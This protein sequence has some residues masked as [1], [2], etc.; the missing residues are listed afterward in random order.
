MFRVGLN[1]VT[2]TPTF[3]EQ[4]RMSL[5][6]VQS[7]FATIFDSLPDR[8]K[9]ALLEE[10]LFPL[11]D[12]LSST[13]KLKLM[14]AAE[15]ARVRYAGL[16]TLDLAA[17]KKEV[18][19][20]FE[21]LRRD[22]YR[23]TNN[24]RRE[25]ISENIVDSLIEWLS[26]IWQT[27]YE[28]G[29]DF[30]KGHQCLLY[31]CEVLQQ[32]GMSGSGCR[33]GFMNMYV[34]ATIKNSYGEIVK[35][36][37]YP[38]AFL[39]EDAF[40]WIWR[41]M[42]LKIL[43][44]GRQ[45]HKDRIQSVLEDIQSATKEWTTSLD[46]LLTSGGK[47][48][49]YSDGDEDTDYEESDDDSD[50]IH[51]ASH[52]IHWPQAHLDQLPTLRRLISICLFDAFKASPSLSLYTSIIA[53]S[54]ALLT[55]LLT[56]LGKAAKHSPATAAAALEIHTLNGDASAIIEV[57][58][59]AR[60]LFRPRDAPSMQSAVHLLSHTQH[61]G[62]ALKVVSRELRDCV[63]TM[64][65]LI[66][67]AAYGNVEEVENKERLEEVMR[68]RFGTAQRQEAVEHW[69]D[70]VATAS[71][72]G[73]P[74]TFAAFLMGFPPGFEPEDTDE[75]D[76]FL[77]S[78]VKEGHPDYEDLREEWRPPLNERFQGWVVQAEALGREGEGLLGQIAK[79]INERMPYAR[80]SDIMDEMIS[81]LQDKPTKYHI[82]DALDAISGFIKT[83][84]HKMLVERNKAEK[85]RKGKKTRSG[86]TSTSTSGGDG[87]G[88]EV[89]N[90]ANIL[91]VEFTDEED[92]GDDEDESEE[93]LPGLEALD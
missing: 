86:N 12:N 63:Q 56:H 85:R 80:G 24:S 52:A 17:K 33:C 77:F 1:L 70:S 13:G 37:S 48:P 82:S 65:S 78:G 46:R 30:E 2:T 64:H 10:Q 47:F 87:S 7:K 38:G 28:Y 76:P 42:L 58:N 83:Q 4:Q 92:L 15:Q 32:L 93:D 45:C 3:Y 18:E 20:L 44:E 75:P 88:S 84:K 57:L 53:L 27:V 66:I 40:L 50:E 16:P 69:V 81:R 36:F 55:P 61:I 35:H 6:N 62:K 25:E 31:S 67:N 90:E 54:P 19:A 22:S 49:R 14:G 21:E 26:D 89:L 60:A 43:A 29:V 74:L 73:N 59:T 9:Q 79:L 23:V 72:A 8:A 39:L 68:M 11:I 5:I 51:C 34:P 41:D 91:F 71:G